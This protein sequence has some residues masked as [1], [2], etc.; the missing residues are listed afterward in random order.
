M[1]MVDDATGRTLGLMDYQETTVAAMVLLWRWVEKYGIPQA[2]YTDKKNV[3][4]P[5]RK[6]TLKE[7][8][9]EQE[10][11]TAF[12]EACEKLG[13][14]IIAAHSPQAKGR[15]ERSNGT[16]Q[17]R[18]VKELALRGIKTCVTS[19]KLLQSGFCD[20][21][22]A[23][24][25]VAPLEEEDYHRPVPHWLNLEDV[26]CFDEPRAVLNDWTIRYK[27]NF[28]QILKDNHPLP[29]PKDKVVL[30]TRLDGSTH[31]IFQDRPLEFR[32]ITPVALRARTDKR[33]TKRP[34]V[35]PGT[36]M[37]QKANKPAPDHP[38][39]RNSYKMKVELTE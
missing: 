29:K 34:P 1:N 2:L 35:K 28:Y 36:P 7:L 10:P 37:P 16:Y 21:L 3:Y 25:A 26:F 8:I 5:T 14:E 27:N 11:E 23:R 39:K 12:G 17:D 31:L 13:I 22:N 33:N 18:L 24:F 4:L 15:V 38:W 32:R 9:A 20:D 6:P 19:D 30:R